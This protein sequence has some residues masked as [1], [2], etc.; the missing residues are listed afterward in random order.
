M[1]LKCQNVLTY[2]L[3]HLFDQKYSK[4]CK[5]YS[6]YGKIEFW[7]NIIFIKVIGKLMFFFL[8]NMD[9]RFFRILLWIEI[10]K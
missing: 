5:M 2:L 7:R 4:N 6:C 10:K 1:L 3:L 8:E 9:F